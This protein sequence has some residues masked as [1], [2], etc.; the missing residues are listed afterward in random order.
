MKRFI[1]FVVK[2]ILVLILSMT[3]LIGAGFGAVAWNV[4][5]ATIDGLRNTIIAM[6]VKHKKDVTK[7]KLKAKAKRVMVAVPLLG[8]A[9]AVWLE[10]SE[11]DDWKESHPQGTVTQYSNEVTELALEVKNEL[12]DGY[13]DP[14]D[15]LYSLACSGK[16]VVMKEG[17]LN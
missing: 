12:L 13:C 14:E 8:S 2:N 11:Y 3:L 5:S 10:K 15:Y 16:Q 17:E 7:V 6:K 4:A 9:Y 1:S